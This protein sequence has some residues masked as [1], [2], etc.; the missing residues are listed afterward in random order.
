MIRNALSVGKKSFAA[1]LVIFPEYAR[2][3]EMKESIE[4]AIFHCLV[5][6]V[7]TLARFRT[8]GSTMCFCAY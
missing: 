4:N 5:L 7:A 8:V 2:F 3:G 1:G 6:F